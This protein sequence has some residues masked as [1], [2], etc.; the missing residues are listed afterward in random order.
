MLNFSSLSCVVLHPSKGSPQGLSIDKI[1]STGSL[2]SNS[3]R[4]VSIISLVDFL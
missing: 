1:K 2:G 3:L 4:K